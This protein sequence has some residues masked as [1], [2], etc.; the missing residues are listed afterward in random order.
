MRF[1]RRK[2]VAGGRSRR[3]RGRWWLM[4]WPRFA[5]AALMGLTLGST[6]WLVT[7]DRLELAADQPQVAGVHFTDPALVAATIG[8]VPG[9]HPNVFRVA[10]QSIARALREVPSIAGAQVV[11]E[12][13]NQLIITVTERQP[14]MAIAAVGGTYLVDETGVV[15]QKLGDGEAMPA[16]LPVVHDDRQTWAPGLAVGT[17]LNDVDLAAVLQLAA[18]TPAAVGSRAPG[19]TVSADD[20]DGYVV[21]P[22][23]GGWRAIFGHYTPTLRPPD[24]IASQVQCLRSLLAADEGSVKTVYL[25]PLE[26]RCGTFVPRATATPAPPA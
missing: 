23:N 21:S 6:W 17:R 15:L 11:A 8:I 9:E 4:S 25:S 18:L 20:N 7:T 12:L 14:V 22:T 24:L 19:L 2:P 16:G 13:P 10:T 5:G 3:A 1:A 26:D